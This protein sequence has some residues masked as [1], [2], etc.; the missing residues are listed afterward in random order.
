MAISLALARKRI[1]CYDTQAVHMYMV[2]GP[3]KAIPKVCPHDK[4]TQIK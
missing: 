1:W 2:A 4:C 3:V